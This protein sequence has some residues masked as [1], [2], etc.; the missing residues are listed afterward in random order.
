M[1]TVIRAI[2]ITLVMSSILYAGS[3]EEKLFNAVRYGK[4]Y[5]S[6]VVDIEAAKEALKNGAN[7]NSIRFREKTE[8]PENVMSHWSSIFG[9]SV[10]RN[11][12]NRIDGLIIFELLFQNGFKLKKINSIDIFWFVCCGW[13][14]ALELYLK[15]GASSKLWNFK[16]IGTYL[17]PVQE[18]YSRGRFDTAELLIK[19][20]A[21]RPS[22]D[23]ILQLLFIEECKNSNIEAIKTLLNKGAK[24]NGYVLTKEG[25][26]TPLISSFYMPLRDCFETAK[27]LINRGADINYSGLQ[28]TLRTTP[29][30]EAVK[31]TSMYCDKTDPHK[32]IVQLIENGRQLINLMLKKGAYVS[33]VDYFEQTPLHIASEYSDV[34]VANLLIENGAKIMP[35]DYKGRTP[36][37]LAK[38]GK[39]I[40]LLKKA[41]AWEF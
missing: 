14:E 38:S 18:A 28:G 15:H 27:S 2:L 17:T 37:D 10:D 13:N 20:G 22:K 41:G 33:V 40:S 21:E 16:K 1:R 11:P 29:L 39:I 31:W 24:I 8:S 34:Y 23:E 26:Y 19:Y 30:H 7:P 9:L 4:E 35:R 3:A 5:G 32:K 36:L 12:R 6:I 25:S